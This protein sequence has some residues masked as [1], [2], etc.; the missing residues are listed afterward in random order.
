VQND[1]LSYSVVT[2]SGS[3]ISVRDFD[4]S[5]STVGNYI[6]FK[7][8]NYAAVRDGANLTAYVDGVAGQTR[9]PTE[10]NDFDLDGTVR[11]GA[12][13]DGLNAYYGHM[14]DFRI[15]DFALNAD[16]VT[17]LAGVK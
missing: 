8:C 1:T 5:T 2:G 9:Q 10:N 3:N 16:E 6:E 4:S 14:Q 11:I 13:E 12:Q 7:S 15:Y 17:Y